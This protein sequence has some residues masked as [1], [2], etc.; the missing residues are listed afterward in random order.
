MVIIRCGGCVQFGIWSH[1]RGVRR[2]KVPDLPSVRPSVYVRTSYEYLSADDARMKH[3]IN[4][5]GRTL[6]R[7]Q[8]K[9]EAGSI[10]FSIFSH[11]LLMRQRREWKH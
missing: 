8:Q 2:D 10:S 1:P 6:G 11:F 3:L 4:T 7:D 5:E 9:V